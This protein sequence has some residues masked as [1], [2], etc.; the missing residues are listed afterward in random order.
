MAELN[1]DKN[2]ILLNNRH[3]NGFLYCMRANIHIQGHSQGKCSSQKYH[4][5]GVLKEKQQK[6]GW[7]RLLDGEILRQMITHGR[8][9]HM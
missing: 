2:V 5:Y 4:G 1:H 7:Q 3:N 6:Q 9:L 8:Q